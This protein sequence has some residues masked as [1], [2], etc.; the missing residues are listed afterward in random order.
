MK[1]KSLAITNP[2]LKDRES[3]RRRIIRSIASSTAI[4]TGESIQE[5]E[6]KL[7]QNPSVYQVKLA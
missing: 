6:K 4:E 1:T 5:I 2:F 7:K 3:A